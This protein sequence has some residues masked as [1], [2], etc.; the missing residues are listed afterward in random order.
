MAVLTLKPGGPHN[1]ALAA[2]WV[3]ETGV[4][5]DGDTLTFNYASGTLLNALNIFAT[6]NLDI[7]DYSLAAS[8]LL[9]AGVD[10]AG[11]VLITGG[12]EYIHDNT[13]AVLGA[14]TI[15]GAGVYEA[16][17]GHD[18]QGAVTLGEGIVTFRDVTV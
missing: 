17:V 4:P 8:E 13:D 10:S 7:S 2:S 5:A 1:P 18:I 11:T 14:V 16:G 15:S 9:A 3:E 6:F 12:G